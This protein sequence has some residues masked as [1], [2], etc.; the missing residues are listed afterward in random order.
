MPMATA[1]VPLFHQPR[2]LSK[3]VQFHSR[4]ASLQFLKC[5]TCLER[6]PGMTVRALPA[7]NET[8]CLRCSHDKHLPKLFSSAN[9]MNPGSLS[10]ELVV[11]DIVKHYVLISCLCMCL[12]PH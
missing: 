5:I 3:M 6:F 7:T 4:L 12:Q 10:P 11:S 1:E 9:N 8:E 2:V